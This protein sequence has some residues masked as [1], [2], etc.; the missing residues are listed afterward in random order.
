MSEQT[1]GKLFICTFSN[2]TITPGIIFTLISFNEN[3]TEVCKKRFLQ[4]QDTSVT[5]SGEALSPNIGEKGEKTD[6]PI[7]CILT[8]RSLIS[9]HTYNK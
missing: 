7:S 9:R 5:L 8:D 3:T 4:K 1:E 2:Y 6:T